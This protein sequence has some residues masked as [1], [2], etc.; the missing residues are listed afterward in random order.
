MIQQSYS[1]TSGR[2]MLRWSRQRSARWPAP[3]DLLPIAASVPPAIRPAY[4]HQRR[5]LCIACANPLDSTYN[6]N[7]LQWAGPS[8]LSVLF[9]RA[10]GGRADGHMTGTVTLGAAHALSTACVHTSAQAFKYS[11]SR[12]KA[13]PPPP[14]PERFKGPSSSPLPP[15][16]PSAPIRDGSIE[17]EYVRLVLPVPD[18]ALLEQLPNIAR[19]APEHSDS[20]A[21]RS[22]D[23]DGQSKEKRDKQGGLSPPLAPREILARVDRKNFWLIQVA[24]PPKGAAPI[25][26]L[27]NKKEVHEKSRGGSKGGAAAK[28]AGAVSPAA[29][30][31]A[32]AKADSEQSE[33]GD[34]SQAPTAGVGASPPLKQKELSLSWSVSRHDLQHK[35]ERCAADCSQKGNKWRISISLQSRKQRFD[36]FATG[37]EALHHA[38]MKDIE[39]IMTAGNP[40]D[41]DGKMTGWVVK[42]EGEIRWQTATTAI[43]NFTPIGKKRG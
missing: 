18:G 25:V 36:W 26:K 10:R 4:G 6:K 15:P 30:A 29:H 42:R 28:A 39:R 38:L 1:S 34:G 17:A 27:M 37:A 16:P 3:S 23:E 33:G 43:F 21:T 12:S 22:T 32:A 35:V 5:M 13:S 41:K 20:S 40:P 19:H 14:A 11:T 24:A 2:A 8:D 31:N 7:N 9:S